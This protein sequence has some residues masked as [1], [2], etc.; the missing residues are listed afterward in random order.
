MPGMSRPIFSRI[1]LI[2]TELAWLDRSI[3]YLRDIGWA[4]ALEEPLQHTLVKEITQESE[5]P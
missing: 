5:A 2:D 4:H 3:T 1:S